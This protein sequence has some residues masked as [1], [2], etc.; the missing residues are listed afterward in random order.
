MTSRYKAVCRYCGR[1]GSSTHSG[2][3][4][5]GAPSSNPP[6]IPGPCSASPTGKHITSWEK[7]G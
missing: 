1:T 3:G 6:S 4:N 2:S 5:G 7:V